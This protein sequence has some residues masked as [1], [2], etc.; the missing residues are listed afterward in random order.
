MNGTDIEK[1]PDQ[2]WQEIPYNKNSVSG[3]KNPAYEHG[4]KFSPYSKKFIKYQ[5]GEA[6]YKFGEE[7]GRRVWEDRQIRWQA[8]MNAKSDEEKADINLRKI[9]RGCNVSRIERQL[10][11]DLRAYNG[12]VGGQIRVRGQTSW[13]VGDIHYQ[14]KIIEFNG[15]FWHANP[16]KYDA[17][18]IIYRNQ[19]AAFIWAKD[20]KKIATLEGRGYSVLVVWESEYR[21]AR[22][23][24]VLKCLDF[25]G[26]NHDI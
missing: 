19:T 3:D 12:D 20:A 13:V 25:L 4:G 16:K 22:K 10:L 2:F 23:E 5:T 26:I 24:T 1:Q 9:W 14:N 6:D 11:G 15:D 7:E 17:D 8:T 21:K 18:D